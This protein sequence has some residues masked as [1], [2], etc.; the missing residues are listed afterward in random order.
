MSN[1]GLEKCIKGA[2]NA[3]IFD[4]E[5]ADGLRKRYAKA[6]KNGKVSEF[7]ARAMVIEQL[8]AASKRD[9]NRAFRT[10][11]TQQKL[12]VLAEGIRNYR[13]QADPA[14]ILEVVLEHHGGY[15]VMDIVHRRDELI[16]IYQAKLEGMLHHFRKGYWKGDLKRNEEELQQ[17]LKD[18]VHELFKPGSSNNELATAFAK[19]FAEVAEEARVRF[20][21]AGGE[22]KQLTWKKWGLPQT[23]DS[24]KI[25]E[26]GRENWIKYTAARLDREAMISWD[27]VHQGR[28]DD[29]ELEE[30]LGAIWDH[31]NTQGA[32]GREAGDAFEGTSNLVD[33]RLDPRFMHFKN[34]EEWLKYNKDFGND[35]PYGTMSHYLES[36]ARDTAAYETLGPNPGRMYKW[37]QSWVKDKYATG[38]FGKNNL[39]FRARSIDE[40]MV[41]LKGV[42]DMLTGS[43]ATQSVRFQRYLD[44]QK[45]LDA[46]REI[47]KTDKYKHKTFRKL[48][49]FDENGNAIYGKAIAAKRKV[50][51]DEIETLEAEIKASVKK[52]LSDQQ[53]TVVWHRL[54]ETFSNLSRFEDVPFDLERGGRGDGLAML[55]QHSEA[56]FKD[57]M[58]VND[59]NAHR[60]LA[61]WS[62]SIRNILTASSLGSA[63]LTASTDHIF[64]LSARRHNKMR[65]MK[66]FGDFVKML[67]PKNRRQMV[68][69]GAILDAAI[70]LAHIEARNGASINTN[71]RS[72]F[73][74]ERVLGISGL[75]GITQVAKHAYVYEFQGFMAEQ[76]RLNW[77]KV[78]PY[79]KSMF[80]RHNITKQDFNSLKKAKRV[81]QGAADFLRAEEVRVFDEDLASR[82]HTMMLRERKFAVPEA[83]TKA[84]AVMSLG[85]SAGTMPGEALRHFWLFRS[86]GLTVSMM[87][88]ERTARR[89]Y[90]HGT[91]AA[92]GYAA[93][94]LTGLTMLGYMVIQMKE[95]KKGKTPREWDQSLLWASMLQGGGLGIIGDLVNT[96]FVEDRFGTDPFTSLMGPTASRTSGLLRGAGKAVRG[97]F[98][99][100]TKEA[101]RAVPG[102]NIWATQLLWERAVV[103]NMTRALAGDE[104]YQKSWKR[105]AKA[106]KTGFGTDYWWAPTGTD[107]NED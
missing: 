25:I 39:E 43:E 62:G 37:L 27:S 21:N 107:L 80:R 64:S 99:K 23:H 100:L 32:I 84:R 15:S 82:L 47:K 8:E 7:Q 24:A 31:I 75:T 67:D 33:P 11:L 34:S 38:A 101:M 81:T 98:S 45:K 78:D 79:T 1:K 89:A 77:D 53:Q 36:M 93:Y 14:K 68:R 88:I 69:N 44:L 95:M 49:A 56:M 76:M 103:D 71:L 59:P 54:D 19:E 18:I 90:E 26:H 28:M 91:G 106:Q 65:V 9:I 102:S 104:K 6:S 94:T 50:L 87:Q 16:S 41:T 30:Y 60:Q 61:L 42:G 55:M 5:Q 51:Q 70:R 10:G 73:V 86:F 66:H 85:T 13:G 92:V 17:A 3:G 63:A 52:G 96:G 20:N 12:Q 46:T 57:V 4:T 22:V 74:A 2:L 48:A 105:W 29:A 35:D 72:G 40:H 58:R 97:D 83:T